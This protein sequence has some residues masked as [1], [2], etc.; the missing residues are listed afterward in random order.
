MTV[1]DF[2]EPPPAEVAELAAAEGLQVV[3]LV[4]RNQLGGLTFRC[5]GVDGISFVKW[6]PAHPEF[7]V[8]AEAARLRWAAQY[9]PVP[10]VLGFGHGPGCSWLWTRALPGVSAIDGRWRDDPAVP[11]RAI[12]AGLRLLHDR[13][14]VTGCP[15][16]W[17]VTDRLAGSGVDR[18][19]LL[20][21]VPAVD[22]LVV[23]HGDACAPN[24]LLDDN[25][26]YVGT[27]DLGALGVADRWA[28]LAVATTNLI[29][30]FP[31]GFEQELLDAYG[32]DHD[33]QRLRYYSQ[34]WDA[35]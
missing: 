34:L 21:E 13:L 15:F 8:D 6:L 14:P 12:G 4:W 19:D 11:V 23:C 29:R 22:R 18:P 1:S 20:A 17:S 28:D 24:T 9:V 31:G 27:V 10:G 3:G 26:R 7:D 33:D 32:V 30:N 2:H 16:S 5:R 35:T 25:G